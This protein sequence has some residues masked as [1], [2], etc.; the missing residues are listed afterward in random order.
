MWEVAQMDCGEPWIWEETVTL[1][2]ET[3]TS[4]PTAA[5]NPNCRAEDFANFSGILV[6]GMTVSASAD[7]VTGGLG[8]YVDDVQVDE[9]GNFG[10]VSWTAQSSGIYDIRIM[11]EVAQMDCGEPWIWEETVT[12]P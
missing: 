5:P 8:L 7:N 3:P 2:S 1:P 11:W 12:L 6:N 9:G 4:E 10:S